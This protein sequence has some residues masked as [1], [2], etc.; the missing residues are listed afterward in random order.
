M[1]YEDPT[2]RLALSLGSS[3]ADGIFAR[4]DANGDGEISKHGAAV[5]ARTLSDLSRSCW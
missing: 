4:I 5:R 3:E 1:R 2:L